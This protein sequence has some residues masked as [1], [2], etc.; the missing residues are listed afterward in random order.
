MQ[1]GSDAALG[2]GGLATMASSFS[3]WVIRRTFGETENHQ[4]RAS[5]GDDPPGAIPQDTHAHADEALGEGSTEPEECR[6][7]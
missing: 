1:T 7:L 4:S 2:G 5:G 3:L 6:T